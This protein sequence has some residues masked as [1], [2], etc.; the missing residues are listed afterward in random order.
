[1][2]DTDD[3]SKLDQLEARIAAAKSGSS[4]QGRAHGQEHYSA[5][6]V[7]W[8]MVTELVAGLLLGF[9]IG[10]GLDWLFGIQPV[11][12]I[13]FTLLGF[14]AGMKTMLRSAEELQEK[15]TGPRAGDDD[16]GKDG[17]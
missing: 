8:R 12:M 4:G 5:A 17:D 11:M 10:Y 9:G 1:M 13:L 3:R 16:E 15:P 2:P 14:V 7:G 6:Q